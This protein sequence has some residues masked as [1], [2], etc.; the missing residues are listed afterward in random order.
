MS[1]EIQAQ[2]FNHHSQ[3]KISGISKEISV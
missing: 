1:A 2:V 3:R